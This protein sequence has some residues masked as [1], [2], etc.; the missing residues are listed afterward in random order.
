MLM[1]HPKE[2]MWVAI[3]KNLETREKVRAGTRDLRVTILNQM[4]TS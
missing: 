4:L 1:G 2:E 3:E